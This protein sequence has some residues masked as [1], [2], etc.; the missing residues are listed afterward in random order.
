MGHRDTHSFSL[1]YETIAI[2]LLNPERFQRL[3][4]FQGTQFHR[5][6]GEVKQRKPHMNHNH[7]HCISKKKMG[8]HRH[9]ETIFSKRTQP[10][11]N[12]MSHAMLDTPQATMAIKISKQT[13]IPKQKYVSE[14][15]NTNTAQDQ[16]FVD[17]PGNSTDIISQH[18]GTYGVLEVETSCQQN[19]KQ[20]TAIGISKM[21]SSKNSTG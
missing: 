2:T 6:C 18:I 15:N 7:R 8:I 20:N 19:N 3:M 10:V 12:N 5:E 9:G 13:W 1:N 17:V 21:M 14:Y 11:G 16:W 4:I